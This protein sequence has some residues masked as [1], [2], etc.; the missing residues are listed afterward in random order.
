MYRSI[1]YVLL[2]AFTVLAGCGPQTEKTAEETDS[3]YEQRI[4]SLMAL[5]TLEEKLGQLNL[6][7]AGDIS[8][9][10]AQSTGIIAKIKEGRVGGL[11]NIRTAERIRATQR[12]AVEES[13][14]GIPLIFGMDVIHGY[15]TVFPIPLGQAASWNPE[16]V[17]TG[18]RCTG[19]PRQYAGGG[20]SCGTQ[21]SCG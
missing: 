18:A 9:G 20:D 15:K 11:F 2:L 19:D 5:M 7:S 17:R 16:V 8:T 3:P 14:L 12:V 10:L 6:P 1:F 13:R 21:F 4:D